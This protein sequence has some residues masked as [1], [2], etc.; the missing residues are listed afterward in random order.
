MALRTATQAGPWNVIATWGGASVPITGDDVD[1]AT[2]NVNLPIDYAAACRSLTSGAGGI[3]T[4]N[5][6]SSITLDDTASIDFSPETVDASAGTQAKPCLIL[7]AAVGEPTNKIPVGFTTLTGI[8]LDAEDFITFPNDKTV[9]LTDSVFKWYVAA[10]PEEYDVTGTHV[11]T[12]SVF[13]PQNASPPN[14]RYYLKPTGAAMT[15]VAS[16]YDDILPTIFSANFYIIFFQEQFVLDKTARPRVESVTS[17]L[18]SLGSY[19]EV[20]GYESEKV[21]I[22][23]RVSF[24]NLTEW[25]HPLDHRIF[26]ANLEQ[27]NRDQDEI[28]AFTWNEGHF[29]L[30]SMSDL[31]IQ[32]EP[33]EAFQVASRIYSFLVSER[34]HNT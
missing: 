1:L 16:W 14:R 29:P 26:I 17:F 34:P 31:L 5:E 21:N 24:D 15:V 3:L 8:F 32:Q 19:M 11:I 7:S 18:G 9:T 12:R 6:G 22:R 28:F 25:D 30:A 10:A 33:G 13:Q 27:L 4:Q 23:G 2:F 20:T